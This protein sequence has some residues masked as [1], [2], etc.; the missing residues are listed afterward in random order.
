MT[1]C[2]DDFYKFFFFS[3]NIRIYISKMNKHVKSLSKKD[4]KDFIFYNYDHLSSKT[5]I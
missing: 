2:F 3:F 5:K 1:K 4:L